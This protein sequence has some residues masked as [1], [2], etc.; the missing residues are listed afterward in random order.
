MT[1]R[2]KEYRKYLKTEHWIE[3]S[4]KMKEEYKTCPFCGTSENLR[5]HHLNY[6]NLGNEKDADLMVLCN[7]CHTQV[8]RGKYAIAILTEE[9]RQHYKAIVHKIRP[10]LKKNIVMMTV[11]D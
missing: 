2:Q 1:D 4:I 5:V 6:D 3:L 11:V 9:E 7:Y 8:H 10:L